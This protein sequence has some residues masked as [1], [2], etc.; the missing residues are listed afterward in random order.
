MQYFCLILNILKQHIFPFYPPG[1]HLILHF[2]ISF[3]IDSSFRRNPLLVI[4]QLCQ[5]ILPPK[6]L[7]LKCGKNRQESMFCSKIYIF[8]SFCKQRLREKTIYKYLTGI[9]LFLLYQGRSSWGKGTK[10]WVTSKTRER[11]SVICLTQSQCCISHINAGNPSKLESAYIIFPCY[12][13]SFIY[14]SATFHLIT[15][16]FYFV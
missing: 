2:D 6:R 7:T 8:F 12:A 9:E 10:S 14:H 3:S 4:R 5:N 13:L 15:S 16:S 1:R 11:T